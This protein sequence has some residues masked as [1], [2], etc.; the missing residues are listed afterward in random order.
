MNY[1]FMATMT[2]ARASK[3]ALLPQS[4]QHS[5]LKSPFFFSVSLPHSPLVVFISQLLKCHWL[6]LPVKDLGNYIIWMLS[7]AVSS[8][9]GLKQVRVLWVYRG[10]KGRK[11]NAVTIH[12]WQITINLNKALW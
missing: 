1:E 7:E 9:D 6:E 4:E 5:H 8:T 11:K 2:P 3:A 10:Q 12:K